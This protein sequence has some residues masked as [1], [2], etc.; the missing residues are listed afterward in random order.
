MATRNPVNA[1]T[2]ADPALDPLRDPE[3]VARRAA[4]VCDDT[5]AETIRVYDARG[6][7]ILAD[8]FVICSGASDPHLRALRSNVDQ[9]LTTAGVRLYNVSGTPESHWIILDFGTIVVHLLSPEARE[10]YR[11]ESLWQDMPVIYEGGA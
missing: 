3:T 9:V 4:A 8:F 7:S 1:S 5:K 10:F 11:L 2:V 6:H